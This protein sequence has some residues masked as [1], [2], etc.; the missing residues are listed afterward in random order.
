MEIGINWL[1]I[2]AAALVAMIVGFIWYAKKI[3]GGSWRQLVKSD[4]NKVKKHTFRSMVIAFLGA[5]LTAYV[6]AHVTY[7]S[8]I[9]LGGS[10]FNAALTSALWVWAGFVAVRIMVHDSLEMRNIKLTLINVGNELVIF[11]AMGLVIGWVGL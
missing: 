1:G 6:L 5:L 10:Y 2:G 9:Y 4:S 3:F 11:L 8:Y 7:L